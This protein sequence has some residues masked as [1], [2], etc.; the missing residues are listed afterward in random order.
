MNEGQGLLSGLTQLP[1]MNGVP[2]PER[3]RALLEAGLAMMQPQDPLEGGGAL[4]QFSG[5]VNAG[6]ESLDTQRHERQGLDQLATD[7][8]LKQGTLDNSVARTEILARDVDSQG[9]ARARAADTADANAATSSGQLDQA[10]FEFNVEGADRAADRGLT[11]AKTKYWNRMPEAGGLLGNRSEADNV[12]AR[13]V[14]RMNALWQA[15]Q[16]LGP[17]EQR[18]TGK[19]DPALVDEAWIGVDIVKPLAGN[20]SIPV[21]SDNPLQ[22]AA[23]GQRSMANAAPHTTSRR[24]PELDVKAEKALSFTKEQWEA[25]R[26]NPAGMAEMAEV[27]NVYPGIRA[28]AQKLLYGE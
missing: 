20:E 14:A 26:D 5:G 2:D 28:Q 25:I 8:I 1:V 3:N 27:L 24:T 4:T 13:H 11:Y 23:S 7:N 17:L 19:D 18:F 15:D 21:L 10:I 12:Q 16:R 9:V 6:L 22:A